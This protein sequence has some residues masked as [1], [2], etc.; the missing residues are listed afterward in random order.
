MV[1]TALPLMLIATGLLRSSR[2]SWSQRRNS[3]PLAALV[4]PWSASGLP[5]ATRP[6]TRSHMSSMARS[7]YPSRRSSSASNRQAWRPRFL[8]MRSSAKANFWGVQDFSKTLSVTELSSFAVLNQCLGN[9]LVVQHNPST[10][11]WCSS[12]HE[13]SQISQFI[14]Q[15]YQW[16]QVSILF[17]FLITFVRF[18][19]YS[20]ELIKALR[21]I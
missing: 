11:Y 1:F 17:L 4:S 10:H 14:Q 12:W 9:W 8:P 21:W 16:H 15:Y 13:A 7:A 3:R 18:L 2:D 20:P 5:K 19:I 6:S